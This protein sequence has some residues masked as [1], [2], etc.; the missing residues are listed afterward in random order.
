MSEIANSKL[1]FRSYMVTFRTSVKRLLSH[2]Q[3]FL[4]ERGKAII[5]SSSSTALLELCFSIF[6]YI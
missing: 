3:Y 4:D 2:K 6:L 1:W 5:I